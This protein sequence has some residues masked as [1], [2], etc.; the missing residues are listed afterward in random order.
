MRSLILSALL[1]AGALSGCGS[2][3]PPQGPRLDDAS[4]RCPCCT[5][6][7]CKCGDCKDSGDCPCPPDSPPPK[8]SN[9][10]P[11]EPGG[12]TPGGPS[13]N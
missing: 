12:P 9:T 13:P 2:N 4:A 10:R 11:S 3:E 5:V 8:V 7:N 6:P 1:A